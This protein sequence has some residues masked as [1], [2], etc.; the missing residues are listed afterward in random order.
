MTRA[1]IVKVSVLVAA[2]ATL[3]TGCG[4]HPGAAAVVGDEVITDARVDAVAAALCSANAGS[5]Q[6]QGK[7]IAS[8]SARQGALQVLLDSELSHQFAAQEGVTPNQAQVSQALAQSRSSIQSLPAD[9]RDDF[10]SALEDYVSGQMM[11]V[12]IGR[13][14]LAQ[15]GKT[16]VS[17]TKAVAAGSA[18]RA[19]F[20]KGVD[21]EVDPRY[22][23][24]SAKTGSLGSDGGS[25][26]VPASARAA[27]GSSP[28]P[29]AGWV[30]ALPASQK[31]S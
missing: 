1:R 5:S 20:A 26:S 29:S 30:A 6:A 15:Q 25:L 9:Q 23:S 27:D 24:F 18:L 3:L 28:D 7:E 31:C 17:D 19:K 8:R 22:G 12:T 11:L 4:T 2:A 16:N 21:I 10:S 14:A 13:R